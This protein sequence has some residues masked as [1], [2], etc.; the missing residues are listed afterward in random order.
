MNILPINISNNIKLLTTSEPS[1][2]YCLRKTASDVFSQEKKGYEVRIEN[3][4]YQ[5]S[6]LGLIQSIKEFIN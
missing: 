5:F 2:S 6:D 3:K 4:L 1:Y